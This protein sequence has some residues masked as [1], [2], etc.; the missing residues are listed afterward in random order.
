MV[1][2]QNM[3]NRPYKKCQLQIARRRSPNDFVLFH[4]YL[5][6]K[7]H[8]GVV[9]LWVSLT[10]GVK[11]LLPGAEV[12]QGHAAIAGDLRADL[13]VL[14]HQHLHHDQ[15]HRVLYAGVLVK[16]GYHRHQGQDVV[17]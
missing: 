4:T 10:R 1:S 14:H 11:F 8:G 12:P 7:E 17:L 5:S 15:V 6:D 3:T 16:L 13:L 2:A 9:V